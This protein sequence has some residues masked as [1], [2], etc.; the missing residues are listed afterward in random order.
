MKTRF[1]ISVVVLSC[2]IGCDSD[3]ATH[4][5]PTSASRAD[6]RLDSDPKDLLPGE[7]ELRDGIMACNG[8][9]TRVEDNYFCAKS[10]PEDWEQFDF[11]EQTY[12]RVPLDGIIE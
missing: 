5:Y 6:L 9:L 4:R 3:D 1:V 7:W 10:V 8:Y 2:V 12:Y 11:N